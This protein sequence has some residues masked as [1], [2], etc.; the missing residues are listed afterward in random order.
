ML[1]FVVEN[2]AWIVL[3]VVA[4]ILT[5][6]FSIA[7]VRANG[8]DEEVPQPAPKT[9]PGPPT[10]SFT[11][12][13]VTTTVKKRSNDYKLVDDFVELGSI[14]KVAAK[15]KVSFARVRKAVTAAGLQGNQNYKNR[16]S[17]ADRKAIQEALLAGDRTKKDIAEEFGVSTTTVTNISREAL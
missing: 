17:T 11:E 5:T 12:T 7:L 8:R 14:R 1:E 2:L 6:A 13:K 3:A 16:V 15:H 10:F 4:V 9:F